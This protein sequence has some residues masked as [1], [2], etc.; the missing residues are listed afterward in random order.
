MHICMFLQYV[1]MSEIYLRA[2]NLFKCALILNFTCLSKISQIINGQKKEAKTPQLDLYLDITSKD[3]TYTV[4]N[5]SNKL[6]Q[7]LHMEAM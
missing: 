5:L 1:C 2:F 6:R 7:W 3:I 4:S